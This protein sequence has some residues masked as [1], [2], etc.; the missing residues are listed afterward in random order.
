M[1]I[2]NQCDAPQGFPADYCRKLKEGI[3]RLEMAIQAEY[4][5]AYPG[6]GERIARGVREAKASAWGTPFPSLFFP[7]FAHLKVNEQLLSA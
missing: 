1:L 7:A 6:D 2:M 5:A 3:K 4:E